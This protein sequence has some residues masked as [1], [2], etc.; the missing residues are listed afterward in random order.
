MADATTGTTDLASTLGGL[1]TGIGSLL[2]IAS[3]LY[4]LFGGGQ[5]SVSGTAGAVSQ[6]ADPF[7]SQRFQYQGLLNKYITNPDSFALSPTQKAAEQQSLDTLSRQMAAQ[8]YLGSGNIL[9]GL[10]DQA[11]QFESNEYWKTINELNL[12]SGA[13]TG[14]PSAAALG[15]SN[16]YGNQQQQLQNLTGALGSQSVAGGLAGLGSSVSSLVSGLGSLFGGSSG[17]SGLISDVSN[18]TNDPTL[19]GASDTL[20]TD[21]SNLVDTSSGLY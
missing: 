17:S 2:S 3:P 16:L 8:G 6:A 18:I 1:G 7:A 19:F 11:S 20:N 5:G 13:Q 4:S 14:S 12:L 10:Q 9:T 21:I 15:I